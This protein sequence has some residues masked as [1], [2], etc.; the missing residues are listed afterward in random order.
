LPQWYQKVAPFIA[1]KCWTTAN[2]YSNTGI[3]GFV[4]NPAGPLHYL[5]DPN[6]GVG[7][8]SFAT[9][10]NICNPGEHGFMIQW[11][12]DLTNWANSLN[13]ITGWLSPIYGGPTDL[14]SGTIEQ[15]G[16]CLQDK[17]RYLTELRDC[18]NNF[19]PPIPV[20]LSLPAQ[21]NAVIT[22]YNNA[23]SL[24][25]APLPGAPAPYAYI[26]GDAASYQ[27]VLDWVNDNVIM[28]TQVD[29]V[30]AQVIKLNEY[31]TNM[32]T[33]FD[34]GRVVFGKFLEEE[35]P[36]HILMRTVN[37]QIT[38]IKRLPSFIIYGWKDPKPVGA[39]WHL[40]RAEASEPSVLP[41]VWAHKEGDV[42]DRET[43]FTYINGNN[44]VWVRATRWDEDFHAG[45][46]LF[47]NGLP[48][49]EFKF[50][51]PN[52]LPTSYSAGSLDT[53]CIK[54][55]IGVGLTED[56]QR[57]YTTVAPVFPANIDEEK[58]LG[59]AFMI[60]LDP[61][62]RPSLLPEDP[63]DLCTFNIVNNNCEEESSYTACC[64]AYSNAH[65][66]VGDSR[67][68]YCM[69]TNYARCIQNMKNI[70][71]ANKLNEIEDCFDA[72]DALLNTGVKSLAGAHYGV[73]DTRP[74]PWH[75]GIFFHSSA[76]AK[77]R[78]IFN[79]ATFNDVPT[80]N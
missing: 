23:Q 34:E 13:P 72:A 47:A 19:P 55:G 28:K 66:Y 46:A 61:S 63:V 60:N 80:S 21:C 42:F 73:P 50:K 10:T 26:P 79:D 6:P 41:S 43:C 5:V 8:T 78:N 12:Y 57:A 70:E 37:N 49:W 25:L 54:N 36:A 9:N 52:A 30:A 48:I 29:N 40:A 14:C 33:L 45:T 20:P 4:R 51:N 11:L 67:I 53:H 22:L 58:G 2:P 62:H 56:T 31:G 35:G 59:R 24:F 64:T 74:D 32:Y 44:D 18:Q 1:P 38:S 39:L 3:D 7:G 75:A 27:I 65:G 68:N 15:I 76:T 71:L 16:T 69:Q 77:G 17:A